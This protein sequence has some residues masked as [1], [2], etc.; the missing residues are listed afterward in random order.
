MAKHLA[1]IHG[2]EEDK[3]NCPFY[4]KIG[5]CR[6]GDRCSRIHHRPA[7]SPTILIKHIFQHPMREAELQAAREGRSVDG[8]VVDEAKA[9]EDFLVFFEN[10]YVELSKFGRLDALHIC[11]NVGDHM[12]GHVYAKF[13]DEE[14]AADALNVMNGRFYDGRK[15]E[16]EFSPVTDFLEA[17]CR[18]FDED[19]C[20]RGGFCNFM[21][22]KPVPMC[23]I[24]D[25]EEDADEERRRE[26]MERAERRRKDRR[27]RKRDRDR[28]RKSRRSRSRS[29]S[30]SR[31]ASRGRS[32][33]DAK[34]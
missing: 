1:R 18:D 10:M 28:D 29:R 31:S 17:R 13:S 15:L 5:A 20:R 33:R 34:E 22:I 8:I 25:M 16:V 9:R 12:I 7:F 3:V 14:E 4:F 30:D 24:R 11:D 26:D 23:L 32:S 19:S 27:R 6:H 21:H 2:T